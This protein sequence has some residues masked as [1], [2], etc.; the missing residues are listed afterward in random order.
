LSLASLA[1]P[2]SA[3]S[4]NVVL[5]IGDDQAWYDH[6]FMRRSGVEPMINTMSGPANDAVTGMRVRNVVR[7]PNIDRLADEGFAYT[8]GYTPSSLC[9]PSLASMVT[10][11]YPYQHRITGNNEPPGQDAAYDNLITAVP[12]LPRTLAAERSY[13]SFQTGKWWE[14]HHS[15]GGFTTGNTANST[16]TA[17]RPPQ[18]SGSL[19]SYAPARHGDWGLIAGRVDY[20]TGQAQPPAPVNHLNT[21]KTVTDFIDAQVAAEEGRRKTQIGQFVADERDIQAGRP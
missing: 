17:Y 13:V 2:A 1:L 16:S 19:P 5:I 18:W 7:T 11:L 10:G 3:Q 12:S 21:I 15:K 20:V 9:R 14:G 8:R 6:S 4:P